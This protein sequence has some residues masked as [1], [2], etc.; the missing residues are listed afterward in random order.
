MSTHTVSFNWVKGHNGQVENERC[1]ELAGIALKGENLIED[2]EYMNSLNAPAK[3]GQIKNEGD[4]CRK[5]STPV[6]KKMN[7]KRKI[8]RNQSFYFEYF[9]FCPGCKTVYQVEA[10][11]KL[12]SGSPKLF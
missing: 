4:E 6:I 8:K 3:T 12:V 9:L 5:C 10:A 7:T 1:D 11:K 2:V